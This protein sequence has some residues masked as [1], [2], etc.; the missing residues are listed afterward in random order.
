MCVL[1]GPAAAQ[2]AQNIAATNLRGSLTC[3]APQVWA[4]QVELIC[5]TDL[6]PL[7]L[8]GVPPVHVAVR[9]RARP[10]WGVSQELE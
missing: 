8:R 1:K 3:G 2:V 4:N 5:Q 9:G 6:Q 10:A 7:L